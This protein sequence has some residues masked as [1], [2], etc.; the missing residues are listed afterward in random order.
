MFSPSR[1]ALLSFL[2]ALPALP[3]AAQVNG[4]KVIVVG[5]GVA[6]LA[7]AEALIRR[8]AEVT[9]LEARNRT[10]GRAVTD[11]TSFEGKPFDLGASLLTI[12]AQNALSPRLEAAGSKI[13]QLPGD[14][15]SIMDGKRFNATQTK[16]FDDFLADIRSTIDKTAE[17]GLRLERLRA[18]DLKEHLA[19]SLIG[20]NTFGIEMNELDALD[21]ATT[22]KGTGGEYVQ[23]GLGKAIAQMFKGIE[24]KLNM[25]V[26]EI[27]YDGIQARVTTRDGETH[28]ADAVIV[29]VSTGILASGKIKFTPALPAEHQKA[30][31]SLPMGLVNKI[32]LE[33]S[34]DIFGPGIKP[35]TQLRA[36]T[37]NGDVIDA[38]LKQGD[39]KLI[40]FTVGGKQAR[41]LEGQSESNALNYALSGLVDLFGNKIEAAFLRGKASRWGVEPWTMGSHTVAR[42]GQNSARET[43]AQPIGSLT[44][45]GEALGG[46]WARTLAGAYLSGREA[47]T[48]V[49]AGGSGRLRNSDSS[50]PSGGERVIQPMISEDNEG[51]DENEVRHARPD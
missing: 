47:A 2:A 27:D 21:A 29:T 18:Q 1:R 42:I 36:V 13:E 32:A 23:G 50:A 5:A 22:L 35:M 51:F 41:Q 12:P 37:S 40:V 44:F 16:S 45:A 46:P 20:P 19:L 11:T 10:G 48:K 17:R 33:F 34:A 14:I 24:V 3:A 26:T 38:M 9:V 4:R 31:D 49:M 39:N 43:L 7:A 8:G 25:P 6:G 28:V 15:I 30:I